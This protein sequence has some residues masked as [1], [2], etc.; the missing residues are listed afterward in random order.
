M[1]QHDSEINSELPICHYGTP[2][3]YLQRDADHVGSLENYSVDCFT[4]TKNA[5]DP[6]SPGFV[7]SAEIHVP[8]LDHIV[9]AS[10]GKFCD[11]AI[12]I[13]SIAD[14]DLSRC[15]DEISVTVRE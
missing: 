1:S 4:D 7:S 6:A 5:R 11:L 8:R 14:D 3:T 12:D 10:D 9:A 15:K 2:V 13:R